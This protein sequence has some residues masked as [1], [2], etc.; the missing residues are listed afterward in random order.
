MKNIVHASTAVLTFALAGP[1]FAT[2]AADNIA[3]SARPAQPDVSS[4]E[5]SAYSGRLIASG[6]PLSGE[7]VLK[8]VGTALLGSALGFAG[9]YQGS[10][11]NPCRHA[12]L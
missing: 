4:P 8:S 11:P 12:G 1:A 5:C 6:V 9:G 3:R 2:T 10:V 7:T